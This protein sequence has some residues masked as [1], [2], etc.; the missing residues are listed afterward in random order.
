MAVWAITVAFVVT[1]VSCGVLLRLAERL[2]LFD[3][4]NQSSAH[5][6]H[7]SV[8]QRERT[9]IFLFSSFYIFA[10]IFVSAIV[11]KTLYPQPT[12]LS[13]KSLLK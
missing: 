11:A 1:V 2:E 8:S 10:S 13:N 7:N 4:P 9:I 6:H 3:V 5:V 12:M